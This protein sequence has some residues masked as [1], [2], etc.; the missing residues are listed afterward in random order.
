MREVV[1]KIILKLY[2]ELDAG[3]HLPRFARVLAVNDAPKDGGTSERFRPRYAVDLEIL[4]PNGERDE[5]FPIYEAVQ[6]PVP[7][8]CG[9]EAGL[10]GFPEPGVIVEIGFAYGRADHPIVRQIYPQG[11][12]LPTVDMGQQRWQQ[13]AAVFQDVDKAGNW[14]RKTD[15][16]ITDTSLR[17]NI[18]AVE[19][20]EQYSR[21][22]RTIRENSVEEIGGFKI[23]EALGA[24]RLRS[25]GSAH[26]TAVDNI[27]LTTARDLNSIAAQDRNQITGRDI[28]AEVK[29]HLEELVRGNLTETTHGSRTEDVGGDRTESTGGNHT[30]DVGGDS[31]ENVAK[32]KTTAATFI[33]MEATTFRIGQSTQGGISLLPLLTSFMEEVRCALQDCADHVHPAIGAVSN[34]QDE[35]AEHS[36][37]VAGL[38]GKVGVLSG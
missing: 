23:L 7:L 37:K 1:K 26:L 25:G 20:E 11:M 34:Q 35:L 22:H 6:L 12:S 18:E 16:A 29:R 3:L 4:T 17:R 19:N 8:G 15:M 36:E 5:S 30:A 32:T 31:T 27:N 9:Q 13:S 2:P 10:F 21:D 24:L 14:T 38:K 28:K 33:N